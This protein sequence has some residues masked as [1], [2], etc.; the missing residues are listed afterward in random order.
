VNPDTQRYDNQF[1]FSVD[2]ELG[3]EFG[4]KK[5]EPPPAPPAEGATPATGG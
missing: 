3:Y 4:G 2:I 1:G 5:E